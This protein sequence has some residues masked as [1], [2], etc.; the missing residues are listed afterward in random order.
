[1]K[2]IFTLGLLLLSSVCFSQQG[3]NTSLG[4]A[5]MG[6]IPSCVLAPRQKADTIKQNRLVIR[7]R[8]TLFNPE[9]LIVVDGLP[10][11]ERKVF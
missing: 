6:N 8:G 3:S 11:E 2:K 5:L 1:M 4:E 9:P 10:C 7:C